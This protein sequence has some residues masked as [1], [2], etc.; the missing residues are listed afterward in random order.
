LTELCP[1][2]AQPGDLVV[3]L[4]GGNVP[5]VLREHPDSIGDGQE[6]DTR[7]EF[8]VECYLQG[9]TEGSGIDEQKEK[10]MPTEVFTLV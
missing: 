2:S 8:V 10:G 5:Y 9:Y 6:R 3:I 1:F 7:Y 4:Y